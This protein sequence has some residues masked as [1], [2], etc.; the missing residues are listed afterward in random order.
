MQ[1]HC[2]HTLIH[3]LRKLPD[4]INIDFNSRKRTHQKMFLAFM[5]ILTAQPTA[6]TPV[7]A[8]PLL[9]HQKDKSEKQNHRT[10]KDQHLSL[11]LQ[12][13]TNSDHPHTHLNQQIQWC[14]PQ[15]PD[16]SPLSNSGLQRS[17][18][19]RLS[20]RNLLIRERRGV[21]KKTEGRDLSSS[22]C[23]HKA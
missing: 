18:T 15:G 23:G 22:T 17:A 4:V 16:T 8:R 1:K 20:Q 14:T 6:R 3:Y 13:G 21:K 11:Q 10:M 5:Q 2:S 19:K 9:L 12:Q 7:S